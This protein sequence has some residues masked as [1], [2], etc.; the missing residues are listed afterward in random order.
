MRRF[1]KPKTAIDNCRSVG[2]LGVKMEASALYA[3]AEAKDHSVIC[4]A[5][6]TNQMGNVEND[7]E[8]GEAQV[9][10]FKQSPA[11]SREWVIPVP[12]S[13]LPDAAPDRH[14]PHA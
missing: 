10:V 4:F 1:E 3:L 12:P 14:S 7:F 2:I 6:K 13:G 8:K 11:G 9:R 5:H